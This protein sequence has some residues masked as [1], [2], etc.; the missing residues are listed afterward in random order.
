MMSILS[1]VILVGG[2]FVVCP[3]LAV[4]MYRQ[5]KDDGK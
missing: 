1:V 4:S 3:V 2:F 5:W